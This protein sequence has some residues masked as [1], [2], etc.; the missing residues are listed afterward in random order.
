MPVV[1]RSNEMQSREQDAAGAGEAAAG[2]ASSEA[3][4]EEEGRESL[5]TLLIDRARAEVYA[6]CRDFTHVP[7][8]M[9]RV[10]SVT[11]VDA[12]SSLWTV[13]DA[14]GQ[15]SKWEVMVT[16]DERDRF[17]AWSTS[18]RTPARCAGR[19]EFE[20]V[21]PAGTTRV[22]AMI[23]EAPPEGLIDQ[24]LHR[25]VGESP[26]LPLRPDLARLKA[27][28]EAGEPVALPGTSAAGAAA[29]ERGI[30]IIAPEPPQ[31]GPAEGDLT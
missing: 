13:I 31:A 26:A 27:L 8:F 6:F 19:F 10:Q 28:L 24:L 21:A 29:T 12:L 17:I 30:G 15:P 20:E 5:E 25:V 4:S 7:R 1:E 18:G 14:Q 2:L 16:D 9:E 23:R 3:S 11:E 22:T